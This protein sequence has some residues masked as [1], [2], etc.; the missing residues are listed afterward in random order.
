M[1]EE[2]NE[3]E[4][5]HANTFMERLQQAS[6]EIDS[7]KSSFTKGMEELAKIQNVLNLDGVNKFN[8]MIQNFE[9]RLSDAE[10][11]REEAAKGARKYSEELEKEKERLVK[12]WDAYKNQEEELSLQE[13]RVL[14]VEERLKE[15]DRSKKQFEEDSTARI[16]T[17][18]QKLEEKEQEFQQLEES[19]QRIKEF[20]DM[21]NRLEETIHGLRNELN[22]KDETIES[23]EAQVEEL[24]PMEK[25]EEFKT[26]F[27]EVSEE[28]EK[29]KER[30][31]KL[32]RLYEETE[33]ENKR[34]NEEVKGWQ[35]WFDSN[36]ELFTK[37]F[38]SVDHLR[39]T[40]K[41]S[42]MPEK[43]PEEPPT[44]PEKKEVKKKRKKKI[45]FKK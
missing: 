4:V 16:T 9:D 30:L 29:E 6:N 34:L 25:F 39:K 27:E 12:L 13:K 43:M 44:T 23:L 1:A 33:S 20:D 24:K 40:T 2:N 7:I 38:S 37:L 15:T 19:R 5:K 35:E 10:R 42:P 18:T 45:R 11:L 3:S 31:T 36:E 21:R 14:E 28:Y 26:R 8:S 41:S 32:F 22:A 17:L